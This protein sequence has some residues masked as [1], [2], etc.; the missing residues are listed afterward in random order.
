[1]PA[2]V[3]AHHALNPD[4]HPGKPRHRARE[5]VSRGLAALPREDFDE[6]DA[7]GVVD[8]DKHVFPA[9][10][11]MPDSPIAVDPMADAVNPPERLNVQMRGNPAGGR[12]VAAP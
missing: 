1:V 8:G 2:A 5:K 7:G 4:A 6:G 9:R 3:I 12:F 10:A 11:P